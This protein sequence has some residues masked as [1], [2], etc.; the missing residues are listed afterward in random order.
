MRKVKLGII[1]CGIAT[2]ELHWPA[3]KELDNCFEVV[4]VC[5]RTE[6]KAKKFSKIV[7]NVP[8]TSDY[9]KLLRRDDIEAVTVCVPII[10]NCK[11]VEDALKAGK[12][13]L[14]EKPIAANIEQAT[15]MLEFPARYQRV[16][17]IAE[18][19][20]YRPV[21]QKAKQLLD[22]G[23]IGTAYAAV[24]NIFMHVTNKNPYARTTWRQVP[25]HVGGFITD[26]GVHQIAALRLLLGEIRGGCAWNQSVNESLGKPDTLSFQFETERKIK[27]VL[28]LFFSAN[29]LAENKLFVMGSKGTLVIENENIIVKRTGRADRLIEI[30]DKG[31][32]FEEFKVFYQ[33]ICNSEF[34]PDSFVEAYKDLA[35][36]LGALRH[37]QGTFS[38]LTK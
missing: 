17:M 12:H 11:I 3:I 1:G 34:T 19:S 20:R 9:K 29:G 31:G 21:F 13:V 2:R 24:W 38:K 28:N 7:G 35:I 37:K 15:Q 25:K 32:F 4:A 26:G 10:S 8:Y 33:K 5:N 22:D 18:N 23:L 30:F 27:G 16:M 36:I 6:S 14:A